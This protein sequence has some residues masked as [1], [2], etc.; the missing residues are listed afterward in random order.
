MTNIS[1]SIYN[2]VVPKLRSSSKL[3]LGLA[4]LQNAPIRRQSAQIAAQDL[5]S[6]YASAHELSPK[7]CLMPCCS[8]N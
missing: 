2:D 7:A 6:N 4:F 1:I 3:R 8:V 5:I